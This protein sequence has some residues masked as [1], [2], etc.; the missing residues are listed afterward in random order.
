MFGSVE[1]E[2]EGILGTS[3]K[4]GFMRVDFDKG[5]AWTGRSGQKR[6]GQLEPLF[7]LIG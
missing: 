1:R 5:W 3:L 6:T 2:R 7:F 4:T